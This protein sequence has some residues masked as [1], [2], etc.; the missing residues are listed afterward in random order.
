MPNYIFRCL[1]ED[2]PWESDE[3]YENIEEAKEDA[4]M[5]YCPTWGNDVKALVLA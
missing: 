1:N 3:Q 5:Q 2:C 4:E